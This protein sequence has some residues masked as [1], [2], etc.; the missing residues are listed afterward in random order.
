MKLDI[1]VPYSQ[2]VLKVVGLGL[3]IRLAYGAIKFGGVLPE[4]Y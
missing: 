4:L 2:V 1:T 3:G